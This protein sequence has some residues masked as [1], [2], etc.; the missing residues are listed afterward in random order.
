MY[1]ALI[2][3]VSN[4]KMSSVRNST[5]YLKNLRHLAHYS[6][7]PCV[8]IIPICEWY[9]YRSSWKMVFSSGL[10]LIVPATLVISFIPNFPLWTFSCY[11]SSLFN[12]ASLKS[13]IIC[14]PTLQVLSRMCVLCWHFLWSQPHLISLS[15]K[16][17]Q[18]IYLL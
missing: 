4:L 14:S 9:H 2:W 10:F 18:P 12:V 11:I 3:I 15:F 1:S 13:A 6:H 16:A 7:Q 8:Q 17:P 5:M